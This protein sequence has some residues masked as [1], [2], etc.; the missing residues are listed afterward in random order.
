MG[1]STGCGA[2]GL[3]HRIGELVPPALHG[4]RLG[5]GDSAALVPTSGRGRGANG[6]DGFAPEYLHA[7]RSWFGIVGVPYALALTYVA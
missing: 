1:I 4:E 5:C 7:R 3:A 2:V 6:V